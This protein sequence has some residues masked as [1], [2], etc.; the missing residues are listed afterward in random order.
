M[1]SEDVC[2]RLQLPLRLCEKVRV[3]DR[4]DDPV[5]SKLGEEVTVVEG[6]KLLVP[7]LETLSLT[8]WVQLADK[9]PLCDHDALALRKRV[10][11]RDKL[12]L[13]LQ[14]EDADAVPE[15][16]ALPVSDGED[17]PLLDSV[18][19]NESVGLSELVRVEEELSDELLLI[20]SD[21][22]LD[23]VGVLLRLAEADVDPE[24]ELLA[25]SD[26]ENVP[27]LDCVAVGEALAV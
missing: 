24:G 20:V 16:E 5:L 21:P 7:L 2:D 11:L 12:R 18:A 26:S 8:G 22:L 27:L 23:H 3:R 9:V 13:L 10:K 17:V 4:V 14:V 19:V 15:G 1:V 25:L 6:D